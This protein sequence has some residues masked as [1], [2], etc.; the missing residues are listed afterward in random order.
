MIS[1]RFLIPTGLL[2]GLALVPTIIHHY[3][4]TTSHDGLTTA[5]VN[6]P[7]AGYIVESTDRREKW[8]TETFSSKDWLENRYTGAAGEQV[9]LFVARAYD[10]KRLY[11][12]PEIGILRGVDLEREELVSTAGMPGIPV[13]FM[14]ER[15]NIGAAAYVILYDGEFIGNP[16]T[17]QLKSSLK[18]LFSA[19]KPLTLFFVYDSNLRRN[20]EFGTSPAAP[21]LAEAVN[22]FTSQSPGS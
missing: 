15:D 8:V 17:M 10:L 21:V 6:G 12:H 20:A 4:A 11:H 7:F 3:A 18:M 2:L 9:L 16:I 22:R 13:H 14:R 19:S 5:A 1:P